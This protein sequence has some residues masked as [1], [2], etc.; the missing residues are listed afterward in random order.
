ME[1]R[2]IE[3]FLAVVEHGGV[4]RAA[5]Q[6]HVSQPTVSASL[7]RLEKELGGLLFERVGSKFVLTSAGKA[8][9][10]PAQQVLQD[11]QVAVESVSEVL[12][13]GG[14]LLEICAVPAVAAGWL[15]DVISR[16]CADF[17]GIAVRVH[18]QA[19]SML[20]AESVRAGRF[21]VG[22]AVI[23]PADSTLVTTRVGRQEL[24]VILPP[25]T[26]DS[27]GSVQLEKLAKLDLI[28]LHSGASTSRRWLEKQLSDKG[29]E[30]RVRIEVANV[31]AIPPLVIAGA[32]Y[33]L[34]WSPMPAIM[35]EKCVMQAPVPAFHRDIYLIVR[36]GALTPG[37]AAFIRTVTATQTSTA[38]P[39]IPA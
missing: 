10:E 2:Q 26:D 6:L 23:D 18:D 30:P 21:D 3:Y 8:L 13:L 29:L 20:V 25:G 22:L 27:D 36:M 5:Q 24:R 31:E 7:R 15:P 12:G 39:T 1:R 11:L 38:H 19:D 16:F 17:P 37:T 35:T 9:V 28:T 4:T 32:G 33:A 34:W 14:G